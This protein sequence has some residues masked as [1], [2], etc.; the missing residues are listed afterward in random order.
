ERGWPDR[1][2]C[3]G[4]ARDD[5]SASV[6]RRQR[7]QRLGGGT[8]TPQQENE[9]RDHL[10]PTWPM[11]RRASRGPIPTR[12]RPRA[13]DEPCPDGRGQPPVEERE[14]CAC[15][16]GSKE[17]LLRSSARTRPRR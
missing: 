1:N 15:A 4:H 7:I 11:N 3:R 13:V 12:A 8:G 14:Y 10:A 6:R 5:R 16:L 2:D 9:E 17:F